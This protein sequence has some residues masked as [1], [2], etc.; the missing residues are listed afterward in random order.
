M[1]ENDSCRKVIYMDDVQG[2][3]KVNNNTCMKAMLVGTTD[4]GYTVF[5][6]IPMS[7]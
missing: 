7:H 3:D 1:R 2:P 5:E 6:C 4:R